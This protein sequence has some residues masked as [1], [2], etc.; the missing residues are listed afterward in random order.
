MQKSSKKQSIE[1]RAYKFGRAMTWHNV[2]KQ[3]LEL[4][5]KVLQKLRKIISEI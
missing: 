2:A 3:H 1:E 5:H 4:F